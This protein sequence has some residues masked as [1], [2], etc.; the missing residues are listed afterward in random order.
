MRMNGVIKG[1]NFKKNHGVLIA[2][3]GRRFIFNLDDFYSDVRVSYL[4]EGVP[5]RFDA[6]RDN[7]MIMPSQVI[8]EETAISHLYNSLL[9]FFKR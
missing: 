4:K 3:D 2:A 7:L 8:K 5:V 6:D 1:F 9:A